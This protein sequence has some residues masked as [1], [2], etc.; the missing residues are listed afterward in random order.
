MRNTG[1]SW[2]HVSRGKACGR[3][4]PESTFHSE[5]A[6]RSIS[7]LKISHTCVCS[8]QGS[9]EPES[10]QETRQVLDSRQLLRF[11][12]RKCLNKHVH[13]PVE[14]LTNAYRSSS[15]WHARAWAQ[16]VIRGVEKR[17]SQEALKPNLAEDVEMDLIGTAIRDDEFH[18]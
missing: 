4:E 6:K 5:T 11:F 12:V 3:H 17:C 13:G 9:E 8:G 18:E 1:N 16:A 14:G 15:C 10:P 7:C 2:E